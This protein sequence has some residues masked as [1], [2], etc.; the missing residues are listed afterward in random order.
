[1]AT[2][3]GDRSTAK[4]PRKYRANFLRWPFAR[5]TRSFRSFVVEPQKYSPCDHGEIFNAA[6]SALLPTPEQLVDNFSSR[7]LLPNN[8]PFD[9]V[10][11]PEAFLPY[12]TLIQTLQVIARVETTGC[13]H[14]GLR[15]DTTDQHLFTIEQVSELCSQLRQLPNIVESDFTA[16]SSWL[17]AQPTDK[18]YNLGCLFMVDS[19]Q[20]LRL[21][22]HPKVVRSKFE[23]S[24]LK[25][26][27]MIGANLITLVT[28]VP[29]DN[30]LLSV[31]LQPL[32]CSDALHIATDRPNSW[33]LE[34]IN[35]EAGEFDSAPPDHVDIISLAT[36]T[37]QQIINTTGRYRYSWHQEFSEAFKRCASDDALYRHHQSAIVASNFSTTPPSGVPAGLSGAFFPL[38]YTSAE[39]PEFIDISV[40]GRPE[41]TKRNGWSDPGQVRQ[42]QPKWSNFGYF[43]AFAADPHDTAEAYMLGFT[44]DRLPRDTTRWASWSGLVD[45][46]LRTSK[47]DP[48]TSDL[49]FSKDHTR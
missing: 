22:L 33:P 43:A 38:P 12:H 19:D 49:A 29:S 47:R 36:C 7:A 40:Y 46:N 37:P 15:P 34:A 4:P 18:M 13:I 25:E 2:N 30:V 24:A 35:G 20:H 14:T 44:I 23:R 31:T 10:T 16:F 1:M 28:L 27:H 45:F 26:H 32:L 3:C 41:N 9:L 5:S 8:E 39:V 42:G 48:N 17:D 6:L 21:C 11:F